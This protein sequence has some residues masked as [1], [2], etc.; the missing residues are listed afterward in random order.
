MVKETCNLMNGSSSPYVTTLRSLVVLDHE[1]VEIKLFKF[2]IGPNEEMLFK[3]HV[4]EFNLSVILT[5]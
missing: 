3:S 5:E 2:L 1:E 4:Q